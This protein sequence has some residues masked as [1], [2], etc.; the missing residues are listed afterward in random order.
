[1]QNEQSSPAPVTV[2]ILAYKNNEKLRQAI[3]SVLAQEPRLPASLIV[4]DND[5]EQSAKATVE[6]FECKEIQYRVGFQNNIGY[7]RQLVVTEASTPYVAFLDSD[8]AAPSH[9]L[10]VLYEAMRL[11]RANNEKVAAVGGSNGPPQNG[12]RFYS[13][14]TMMRQVPW[15]HLN[16]LQLKTPRHAEVT[17]HLPST[18]VLYVREA[19]QAVGSFSAQNE[20]FGED[21]SISHRLRQKGYQLLYTP[22][23]KVEH[24]ESDNFRDWS[25]RAFRFGRA[26]LN[27]VFQGGKSHLLN[28]RVVWPTFFILLQIMF[29]GLAFFKPQWAWGVLGYVLFLFFTCMTLC[30]QNKKPTLV[31]SLMFLFAVSHFAYPAGQIYEVY[32]QLKKRVSVWIFTKTF[33][34]AVRWAQNF[35]FATNLRK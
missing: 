16:S 24:Y 12:H 30:W 34:P 35:G 1:M 31:L 3:A 21:L 32:F 23:A 25:Q 20:K 26:Q 18:N 15:G 29:A 17:D 27:L 4:V 6:S 9:W 13:L 10:E 5:S 28:R 2:A 19:V 14:I 8:C 7:A 22:G 11:A 33:G